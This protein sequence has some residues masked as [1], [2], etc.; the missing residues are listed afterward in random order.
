MVTPLALTLILAGF[1]IVVQCRRVVKPAKDLNDVPF[2][3][4]PQMLRQ[5]SA[6]SDESHKVNSLPGFT[7]SS[8]L[9]HYAG[10][11]L[12]DEKHNG[13][14]FYWLFES[15]A[16]SARKPLVIWLNGGPG[17]SSMDGLFLEIGPFK[18]SS[19]S[20]GSGVS[21]A[22]N[23]HSWHTV[24]NL[25]FIDQPVGTGLSFT[26]S[27]DGLAKSDEDVNRHFVAFLEKF[28]QKYPQYMTAGAS[29]ATTRPI[30]FAGE[31]HAGHYILSLVDHLL[32]TPGSPYSIGGLLLG[33]PWIH[34]PSQY[35]PAPYAH[36]M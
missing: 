26:A 10:H 7:D 3:D 22:P 12:V 33:N 2:E 32:A 1:W 29:P 23:P 25:L 35:N 18:I 16:D 36:A 4:L 24:A 15:P 27:K 31:S 11:I 8:S 20:G 17:C 21:L 30:F 34:P 14:F 28:F 9:N 13:H 5:L 19:K 6:N